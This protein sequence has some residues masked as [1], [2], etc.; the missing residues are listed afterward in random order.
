MYQFKVWTLKPEYNSDPKVE[1]DKGQSSEYN[2]D[3][4]LASKFS[5]QKVGLGFRKHDCVLISSVTQNI[6]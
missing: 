3:K 4:N 6:L 1:D 5:L 2:M